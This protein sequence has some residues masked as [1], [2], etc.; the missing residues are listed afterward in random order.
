MPNYQYLRASHYA[1]HFMCIISFNSYESI[2][3]NPYFRAKESEAPRGEETCP[4]DYRA[5]KIGSQDLSLGNFINFCSLD[6]HPE[7]W[8]FHL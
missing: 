7:L 2:F 6:Y 4:G 8:V 5:E 1:K 3:F